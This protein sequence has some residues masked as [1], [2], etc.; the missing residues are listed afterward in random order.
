MHINFILKEENIEKRN[1]DLKRAFNYASPLIHIDDFEREAI[2][3]LIN[4]TEKIQLCRDVLS[5]VQAKNLAVNHP[6]IKSCV[7]SLE[8]LQTHNLKYPDIRCKGVIR[9]FDNENMRKDAFGEESENEQ[10]ILDWSH[11]A[12]YINHSLL[13]GAAFKLKG[14][15]TSLANEIVRDNQDVKKILLAVGISESLLDEVGQ[16][17]IKIQKSIYPSRIDSQHIKQI[18]I[19]TI[20]GQFIAVTPLTSYLTQK[21]IHIACKAHKF[22]TTVVRHNHSP[23]VGGFT[24]ATGGKVYALHYPIERYDRPLK[25]ITDNR[26]FL[27]NTEWRVILEYIEKNNYVRTDKQKKVFGMNFRATLRKLLSKWKL[28]QSQCQQDPKLLS[29]QFHHWLAKTEFGHKLSYHPNL[30]QPVYLGIKW[31]LNRQVRLN[32]GLEEY[33][34]IVLPNLNVSAANAM[35]CSA[36]C[37]MPS[38]NAF[39]GFITNFILRLNSM[40]NCQATH[41]SF[42]LCFHHFDIQRTSISREV[43]KNAKNKL[44]MP[45][46]LD[47]RACHFTFSLIVRL[48][49]NQN[50]EHNNLLAALPSRLAG[51]AVH[52]PIGSESDLTIL[53]SMKESVHLASHGKKGCWLECGGEMTIDQQASVDLNHCSEYLVK[54]RDCVP[55]VS[56]MRLLQTPKIKLGTVNN[57]PHAFAEQLISIAK[58]SSKIKDKFISSLFWERKWDEETMFFSKIDEENL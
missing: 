53:V 44:T 15:S 10:V 39:D 26:P 48:Q 14:Q 13:F 2:V 35:A 17:F 29:H 21:N 3:V 51:G 34:Y 42:A 4:L 23:S 5:E 56:G 11:N 46:V 25:L 58:L 8:F 50:I 45:S 7:S 16:N 18:R 37:G 43:Y 41:Q 19:K 54:N 27:D 1:H 9:A 55:I 33:Q 20:S 52:L 30:L 57:L 12:K 28:E 31:L 38:L 32:E 22:R 6:H 24:S 47:D 40:A 49:A 36:L